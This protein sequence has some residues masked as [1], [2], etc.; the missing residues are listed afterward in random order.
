MSARWDRIL[1]RLW[2]A[3]GGAGLIAATLYLGAVVGVRRWPYTVAETF[4]DTP[5]VP[6]GG[7]FRMGRRIAYDDAC[8]LSYGRRLQSLVPGPRGALRRDVLP[9][10]VFDRP[11]MDLDGKAWSVDV[12]VPA[13]FP[14]GPAILVDSPSAACNWFQRIFWRQRRPDARTPFTVACPDGTAGVAGTG[15]GLGRSDRQP[16]DPP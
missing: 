4:V 3:V 16:A 15:G 13:D 6:P 11:P 10:I 2:L 7:V 8:E 1:S 12:P 14:C 5:T 9:D